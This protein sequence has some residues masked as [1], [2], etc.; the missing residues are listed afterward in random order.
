MLS[1]GPCRDVQSLCHDDL[2]G[3]ST[4]RHW[5][6]WLGRFAKAGYF[7]AALNGLGQ[8]IKCLSLPFGGFGQLFNGGNEAIKLA[9]ARAHG[10]P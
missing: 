8:S 6:S 9:L 3:D 1:K 7:P 2:R 10:I 4:C 5:I